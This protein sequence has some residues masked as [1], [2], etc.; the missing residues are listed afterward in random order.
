[1]FVTAEAFYTLK[2]FKPLT[3]TAVVV[4]SAK[5]AAHCIVLLG[6]I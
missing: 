6:K 3:V 4:A 5:E 1:M 2:A